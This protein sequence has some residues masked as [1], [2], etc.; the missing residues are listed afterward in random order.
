MKQ[1]NR[2]MK[3]LHRSIHIYT[4]ATQKLCI[5]LNGLL[6]IDRDRGPLKWTCWRERERKGVRAAKEST[7]LFGDKGDGRLGYPGDAAAV[8][9][10]IPTLLLLKINVL[11]HRSRILFDMAQS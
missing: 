2:T 4:E 3:Y 7:F 6:Q 5:H 9:T 8:R 10:S 11:P 1:Y